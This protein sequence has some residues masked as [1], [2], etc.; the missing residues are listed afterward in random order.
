MRTATLAADL[1]GLS[2]ALA[3][4]FPAPQPQVPAGRNGGGAA[5][6]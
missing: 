3:S 1:L 6:V 2:L 5:R 4:G